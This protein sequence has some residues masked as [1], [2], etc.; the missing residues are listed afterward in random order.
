MRVNETPEKCKYCMACMKDG[1]WFCTKHEDICAAIY[2][3]C[4]G[5]VTKSKL[6][7]DIP[8]GWE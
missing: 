8:G 1:V 6:R 3:V 2:I 4:T 5:T 7:R